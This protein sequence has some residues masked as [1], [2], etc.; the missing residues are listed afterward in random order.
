MSDMSTL[1]DRY[2]DVWNST[3]PQQRAAGIRDLFAQGA[4]YTDPLAAVAGHEQI[5]QLIGGAQQ[6]FA[7]LRFRRGEVFDTNH[8]IARFTWELGGN[9]TDDAAAI[10]YDVVQVDGDGRIT[11]VLG[12]LDRV[13]G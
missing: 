1:V 10:G 4:T 9:G 5:D 7:G 8:D 11:Q 2:I 6:Q 12:F 13:P 3:D